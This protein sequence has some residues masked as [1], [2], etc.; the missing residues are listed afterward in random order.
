MTSVEDRSAVKR[1]VLVAALGY[2]VDIYDLILFSVVRRSSLM[3]LRVAEQ[4][5]LS[6]GL[7][8]LNVQMAGMLIGGVLWGILGDKRGRVSVLYA[9]IALYSAANLLNALVQTVPQYAALRLVAGIGLAGEL[10]AGVTLVSEM[11]DK[12]DRGW[13]TMIVATVGLT[14]A[15]V[16]ALVGDMLPWRGAYVLGGLLGVSLLVVRLKVSES[17]LFQRVGQRTERRGDFLLLFDPRRLA[18]YLSVIATAL[19]I[20][21]TVAILVSLSPEFA[22]DFSMRAM[23]TAGRAILWCYAG[24][25]IG[26]LASGALSQALRSRRKVMAL[27]LVLT[28]VS[29]LLFFTAARESLFA[30]YAICFA[31]GFS[32]GYWAV[33][34]AVAAESFGTNVR[35][36]VATTVPNFVRGAVVPMSLAFQSAKAALGLQRGALTVFAVVAL[37]AIVAVAS[38]DESF[39]RDLDFIEK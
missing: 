31:L 1:A 19:P 21:F 37:L 32:S 8:L 5:L 36:T 11:M 13:G 7:F 4:R 18:R 17:Q 27:F 15:V 10:G 16:A 28:L 2:F 25:S 33:F 20:W 26:D 29:T 35:A 22:Q 23:P 3:S 6:E 9:S 12:R 24:L 39:G 30:F 14:G 34:M 38:L